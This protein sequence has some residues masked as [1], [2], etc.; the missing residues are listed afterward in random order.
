MGGRG[1]YR[2]NVFKVGCDRWARVLIKPASEDSLKYIF[3]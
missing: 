1:Y 3:D 2:G